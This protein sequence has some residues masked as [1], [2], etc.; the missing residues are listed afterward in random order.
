MDIKQAVP[1]TKVRFT[2][3]FLSFTGQQAG[4]AGQSRWTIMACDCSLCTGKR[5]GGFCAVDE[6][7]SCQ[8]DPTGYED[9]PVEERPKW[10][11]INL[12]NLE[13]CPPFVS[14]SRV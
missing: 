5:C 4:P 3:N 8:E 11:H 14:H 9:I 7:H 6:P 2:G 10:K 1:G 12:S 13:R